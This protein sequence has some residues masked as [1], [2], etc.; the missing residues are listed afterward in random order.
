[1]HLLHLFTSLRRLRAQVGPK[2]SFFLRNYKTSHRAR[3]QLA[4]Q[5]GALNGTVHIRDLAYSATSQ[6]LP[7]KVAVY[8]T[9]AQAESLFHQFYAT[10]K[11]EE[12]L[13]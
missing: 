10:V 12:K 1:M 13:P 5:R 7:N 11:A 9:D 4:I 8:A 2:G 6:P 3:L